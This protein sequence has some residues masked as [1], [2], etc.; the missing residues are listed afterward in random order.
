MI[1]GIA[2]CLLI[3]SMMLFLPH[4]KATESSPVGFVIEAEQLEGTMELPS[5]ETGD[6]PHLPNVPM[7]LLK[8]QHASATKLK[9]T[10]LVHSP[11]GM[12]S[13]EMSSDD[14]SSFD[15]LSLKVTNVQFKEIYK[16]EHGNI[17][18]KHVKVLAHAVTWEQ[19]GLPTLHVGWKQG[20]PI[21]MEP[22]PENVLAALKE[23][24]EQLLQSP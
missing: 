4:S 2:L 23:K 19:A 1:S 3:C 14:V 20:E 8:F 9:V 7:L 18:F 12:I 16:P 15:H 11:D 5:I 13:M 6:T 17:G 22:I 24:L 21:N 10:K